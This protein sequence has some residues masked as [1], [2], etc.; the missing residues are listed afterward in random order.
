[1]SDVTIYGA[2]LSTYVRSCCMAC[3]EKG[4]G[5]DLE[6]FA[7]QS[8]EIQALNPTGQVPAF[9]HGDLLLQESSAICRYID[10]AFPGEKL[11]PDDIKTRALMNL[12]MSVTADR[13]YQ[14]MIRD[15]ILPRFGIIEKSD[16]EI[17]EAAKVL[18]KQLKRIDDTLSERAYLAGDKLTLADLFLVPILFWLKMTPEG[19]ASLPAYGSLDRW[20]EGMAERESFKQTVPPMP[21]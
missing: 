5:Y 20:Y 11:Q 10:E 6:P 8:P 17:A 7:P 16:A 9:K 13:D 4:V 3:I 1:M 21:G 14:T 12:W 18:D 2:P 15:V 19:Q